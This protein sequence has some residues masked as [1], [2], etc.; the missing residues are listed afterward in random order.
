MAVSVVLAAR[1]HKGEEVGRKLAIGARDGFASSSMHGFSDC[2]GL[3]GIGRWWHRR[4]DGNGNG[5]LSVVLGDAGFV[6]AE[7]TPKESEW[8]WMALVTASSARG[9]GR[10]AVDGGNAAGSEAAVIGKQWKWKGRRCL[11][12]VVMAAT[13]TW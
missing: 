13:R 10:G 6:D 8:C 9:G 7:K 4:G 2:V 12:L 1:C 3:H 11:R 5:V